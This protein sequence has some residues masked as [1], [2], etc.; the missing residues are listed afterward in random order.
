[1]HVATKVALVGAALLAAFAL[2]VALRQT[3]PS[4]AGTSPGQ[5]PPMTAQQRAGTL[6][7]DGVN[8]QDQ[9][10][11]LDAVAA[12]RPEARRLID[13]VDGAVTIRVMD[14]GATAA[15]W[16]QTS[17]AG[18]EVAIDLAKVNQTLGRRGVIRTVLHELGHVVDFAIVPPALK[19]QL[20]AQVP[21]GYGPC[22]AGQNDAACAV[23][24]ER[25][26]ETFS[27]W[28][29]GDIGAALEIGYRVPPP[30]TSLGDWG[31]PLAQL[32]G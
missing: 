31:R 32:Q 30:S 20:D 13:I 11:I 10:V 15:G 16:T 26:A 3:P 19:A 14:T 6:T 8:P 1:M 7:F 18:Y 2:L 23:R 22:E 4:S 5:A 17:G 27:K 28:A 25:F 12:A 9:R 24:A 29:T 21:Q